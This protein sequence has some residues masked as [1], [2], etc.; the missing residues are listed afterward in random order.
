MN[1]QIRMDRCILDVG[2]GIGSKNKG[3]LV[4][5]TWGI[6]VRRATLAVA[7]VAALGLASGASWVEDILGLLPF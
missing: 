7:F 3:V 1:K 4:A 2:S 6:K 5:M